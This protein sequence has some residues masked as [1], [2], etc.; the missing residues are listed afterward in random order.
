MYPSG[1]KENYVISSILSE[2]RLVL[3]LILCN[4]L[5]LVYREDYNKF[6]S[7][8]LA[9]KSTYVTCINTCRLIDLKGLEIVM[10]KCFTF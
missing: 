9:P 10:I 5:E 3:P 7:Y 4:L 8:K 6:P 2:I 1:F